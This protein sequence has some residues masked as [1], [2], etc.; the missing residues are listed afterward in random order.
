MTW[1]DELPLP[2]TIEV[3]S[4]CDLPWA[5]HLA[6]VIDYDDELPNV[7]RAVKHSDCVQLLKIANQGPP[8]P[9]GPMGPMGMSAPNPQ[10]YK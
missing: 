3:C 4:A 8:G 10:L 9:V 7:S 2:K 5:D 6:L 1:H